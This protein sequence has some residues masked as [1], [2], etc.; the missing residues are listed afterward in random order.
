MK[1]IKI[2]CLMAI[3]FCLL[4]VFTA[5]NKYAINESMT[6]AD[7]AKTLQDKSN[8]TIEIIAGVGSQTYYVTKDG[9]SFVENG[10][11]SDYTYESYFVEGTRLY[12]LVFIQENGET[13]LYAKY[14]NIDEGETNQFNYLYY[15]ASEPFIASTS[16]EVKKGNLSFDYDGTTY[17]IGNIGTTK[18]FIHEMLKNYKNT[19]VYEVE[20]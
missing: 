12:H 13:T 14:K 18:I 16:H 15:I 4:F 9:Y 17:K 5:C 20:L 1:K 6:K 7:I 10:L 2:L 3:V 8:M 11:G 19:A